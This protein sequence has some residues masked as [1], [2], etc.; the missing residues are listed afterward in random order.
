MG[1]APCCISGAEQEVGACGG[2][3]GHPS[4]WCPE[5]TELTGLS[6]HRPQHSCPAQP[7]CPSLRAAGSR[8][9]SQGPPGWKELLTGVAP[10]SQVGVSSTEKWRQDPLCWASGQRTHTIDSWT[11]GWKNTGQPF[12]PPFPLHGHSPSTSPGGA[13]HLLRTGRPRTHQPAPCPCPRAH[14]S[15]L[16]ATARA[17]SQGTNSEPAPASRWE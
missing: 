12:H 3:C 15:E 2:H 13:V 8:E 4:P 9:W 1:P 10:G 7:G 5:T 11:V 6:D 14:C 17:S 16:G